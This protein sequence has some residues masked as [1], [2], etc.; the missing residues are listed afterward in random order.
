MSKP[1][2]PLLLTTHKRHPLPADPTQALPHI[3]IPIR[4]PHLLRCHER[5]SRGTTDTVREALV[6]PKS[7]ILQHEPSTRFADPTPTFSFVPLA[8]NPSW[9]VKIVL[10]PSLLLSWDH[11]RILGVHVP[12][13]W[14]GRFLFQLSYEIWGSR[15]G[16]VTFQVANIALLWRHR[17]LAL[18]YT[19]RWWIIT[20]VVLYS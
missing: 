15:E 13:W 10:K 1:S 2:S 12:F 17:E 6:V 4:P 7:R 16:K 8:T 5:L 11:R 3:R 14:T 20:T 9:S 19:V 18:V